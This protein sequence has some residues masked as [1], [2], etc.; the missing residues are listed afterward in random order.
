M[1][2]D[3]RAM[4]ARS[5]VEQDAILLPLGQRDAIFP[6]IGAEDVGRVATA[7]L[8]NE[9]TDEQW[10]QGVRERI[11]AHAVD[12]L[13]HLWQFFRKSRFRRGENGF[14]PTSGE[15]RGSDGN[16]AADAGRILPE[17]HLRRTLIASSTCRSL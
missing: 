1:L 7:L 15:I 10:A 5:L 11:N 8:A 4:T 14:L 17:R 3:V 9:G 6:L 13:S 2:T 16:S 12:H